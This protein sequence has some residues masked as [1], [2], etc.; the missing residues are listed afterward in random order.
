MLQTL[1]RRIGDASEK[2][3]RLLRPLMCPINDRLGR[4]LQPGVDS[5]G[6]MSTT[7]GE[8]I[9]AAG[10][11]VTDWELLMH[12]ATELVEQRVL[13][14]FRDMERTVLCPFSAT[15]EPFTVEQF[16][17]YVR[18]HWTQIGPADTY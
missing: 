12:R 13:A 10:D 15:D 16:L 1:V 7:A 11:A 14:R 2:T 18:V 4:S 17:D 8:F 3:S 9:R 6:W 5:V